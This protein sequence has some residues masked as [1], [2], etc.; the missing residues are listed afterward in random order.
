MHFT[1]GSVSTFKKIMPTFR[2]FEVDE[3]TMLPVKIHTY[4]LDIKNDDS[5]WEL[6]HTVPQDLNLPD[7][8]PSSFDTILA[9]EILKNETFSIF[10]EGIKSNGGAE[11]YLEE[12]D[13]ECRLTIFCILK[14]SVYSDARRCEGKA[15]INIIGKF[16][17]AIFATLAD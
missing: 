17:H 1:T 10:Y 14:H 3:E 5:K 4:K 6:D 12:C 2:V 8:S 15:P 9:N 11:T 16:V 13:E 7:L